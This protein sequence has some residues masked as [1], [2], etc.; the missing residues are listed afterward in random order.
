MMPRESDGMS[1]E[2]NFLLALVLTAGA[3]L[4]TMLGSLLGLADR[5]PGPWLMSLILGFSGGV[6]VQVSFDELVPTSRSFGQEH[7]SV[8]GVLL[9]MVVMALSLWMLR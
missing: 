3:G 6:M 7:F 8:V 1:V 9:G 4:A 2:R 5:K